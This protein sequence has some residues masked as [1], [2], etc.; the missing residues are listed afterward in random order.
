MYSLLP[1]RKIKVNFKFNKFVK[2]FILNE[3]FFWS[4]WY[5]LLPILASF[6]LI[7]I[8]G[9]RVEYGIYGYTSYVIARI[10]GG[11]FSS[12]FFPKPGDRVKL[13]VIISCILLVSISYAI[14]AITISILMFIAA[15]VLVGFALGVSTPVRFSL[16]SEHLDEN[17]EIAEWS[18]DENLIYVGTALFSLLSG[19]ILSVYSFQVLF[20]L[21]AA[22]NLF[23]IIP[24]M[25]VARHISIL[26]SKTYD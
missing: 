26:R 9:S 7:T 17:Q 18:M 12:V 6:L 3:S 2:L 23:S 19:I 11:F 10:M 1:R 16:F 5:T 22:L 13:S 15:Y 14:F 24:M 21:A 25:V 4:I 8:P 20:I